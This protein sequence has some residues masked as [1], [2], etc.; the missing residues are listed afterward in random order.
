MAANRKRQQGKRTTT[1][2]GSPGAALV[3]MRWK[4]TPPAQRSAIAKKLA[5]AR[6][7]PK[8]GRRRDSQ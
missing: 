3:A 8:K 1:K 4:K 6:W 5:E 7:N 2:A